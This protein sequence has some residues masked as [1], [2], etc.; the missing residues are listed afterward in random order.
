MTKKSKEQLYFGI[1]AFCVATFLFVAPYFLLPQINASRS[2]WLQNAPKDACFLEL[3]EI[4]TFE[5]GSASR[6]RFLE[7]VAFEYQKKTATVYVIVRSLELEQAK[8]LL[9]NGTTPDLISFGLGAGDMV[10]AFAQSIDVPDRVRSDLLA[11]GRLEGENL[12]VPWCM[13]GYVLCSQKDL[14]EFCASDLAALQEQ[15]EL[16]IIGT[17][18]AYNLPSRALSEEQTA[19]LG[20]STR[21]QYQAYEAFLRGNEFEVLLGTQ[22]DFF[23]INNK[24]NLGA[25]S[26]I[27]YSYLSKYT[28]LLQYMAITTKKPELVSV[29]NEFIKYVTDSKVQQKLTSIGMFS[30]TQ[31]Y[32]YDDEYKEF[33]KALHE[34]LQ[35]MNVFV[36]NVWLKEEQN[37]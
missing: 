5:G 6:A 29:A 12:A 27:Y 34:K 35:V 22:R 33:E 17:G 24:V 26:E 30:V 14:G 25:I 3:W 18:Y 4:D 9:E 32:I 28:D 11:G 15:T 10:S 2:Q 23:R 19:F 1:F 7:K 8:N 20:K 13:G 21:S 31:D 16:D 36:S 37:K